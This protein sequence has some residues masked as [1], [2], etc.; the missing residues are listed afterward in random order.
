MSIF[1]LLP[2]WHPSRTGPP[3]PLTPRRPHG[4]RS[5]PPP[6]T[7]VGVVLLV[8]LV[9]GAMLLPGRLLAQSPVTVNL[10][11]ELT[12]SQRTNILSHLSLTRVHDDVSEAFFALL[13]RKARL[14]TA[15]A[16]E[17]FG[18]YRPEITINHQRR[19]GGWLVELTVAT[20]P[21]V[22]VDEVRIAL[23]G[24]GEQD[25]SLREAVRRFPLR[26]GNVLDHQIYEQGKDTLIGAALERGFQRAT[27]RDNRVEISRQSLTATLLLNLETGPRYQFGPLTFE[28]DFI[29][30]DLLRKIASV[31]EGDPFSPR[32]LTRLRQSMFNANYFQT[33][34][35]VYDLDQA[36]AARVPVTVVLTPNLAHR[37]GVGLGY[38]TDTGFR[39]TLEYTN[40]HINRYGHQL[41]VQLRPAE[42]K[43]NLSGT[44]TIPIGDPRKDR[45]TLIGKYETEEF[46]ATDTKTLNA[47]ISHDHFR[48]W[49]EYSTFL[50]FI[51]ERY[52]TGQDSDQDA[53]FIPGI[54]GSVF[55]A[56]DRIATTRGIR[57]TGTLTGSEE[58]I[59]ADTS[60]L[61]A[62]LRTKAIYSF[63]DDWRCIG[64]GEIGTTL[65]DDIYDLP[66]TLRYYAGGDQSVRGYGY[67]KIGPVDSEGNV[68]GGKH[69][70]TYSL[71]LERTLFDAWSGAI[72]YDS[73]TAMN[74]FS[75]VSLSS[76]AG[77]GVRWNG[78]FGQIRLDVARALD[79]EGSWRIHFTM[80]ADL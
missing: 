2:L 78:V 13:V 27:F 48:D 70:L 6:H 31:R 34:D 4:E 72:F 18:Y 29:D 17:P 76:G 52:S 39:T 62:T 33:V 44:Y 9:I 45:L 80:G 68:Q 12:D 74:D 14:E 30:H 75:D 22:T 15:R 10:T 3:T 65:V 67:K 57:F 50:Q 58:N 8:I 7:L 51:D 38:G 35:V 55:W 64:R 49:G 79:E 73:G 25:E 5:L 1:P 28:A 37:Y 20:G 36:D 63:F 42:R 24:T 19:N 59:L 11:G 56:D 21:P 26:R 23:I 60:F 66:P 47:I 53:L 40:R 77:V 61:Q 16:L 69:L 71:E 46:D 54:K 32:S 43:S 41:D